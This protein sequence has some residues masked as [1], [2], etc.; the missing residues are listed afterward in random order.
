MKFTP[1]DYQQYAIERVVNDKK[2][3]LFLDM[4]LGK[5]VIALTAIK[6]LIADKEISKVLI[7]APLRVAKLTWDAEI[8]KWDH[9]KGLTISKILGSE[10]ERLAALNKTAN[11]YITNRENTEWLVNLYGRKWPFD[12]V[13]VD[14]LSSFKSASAKRFKALRKV[15]PLVKRMVGLTGTPAPNGLIDLWSQLYLLDRGERLGKTITSYRTEYFYPG[16]VSRQTGVVYNYVLKENAD[17]Q[18]HNKISDICVSMKAIDYIQVP[19]MQEIPVHVELSPGEYKKYKQLEKDLLLTVDGEN[20]EALS[21][22]VLSNKLLQ[23]ANGAVYDINGKPHTIHEEKL[24]A[25]SELIE[26]AN[27]KPV[28]IYYNYKHDLARIKKRLPDSRVLENE[29][30]INDWNKGKIQT[31]LLHPASAGHGLNLQEGGNII[32]WFGL[33]WSL[34]LYQQANARL[35]RQGQTEKVMVYLIAVKKTID[36]DVIKAIANKALNQE[37]LIQAIKARIAET[38]DNNGK[39]KIRLDSD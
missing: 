27:G 33:N 29:N 24:N 37:A 28:I 34:E 9:L 4:G 13:V 6:K 12:M 5:S 17:K 35:H 14:E 18:I 20:I 26:S 3:G 23:M 10:K 11:I 1:Y 2:C 32:I 16:Q 25:L 38:E 7:I 30:D 19:E 31:L 36:E 39:N 8:V 22:A 15:R 21:A